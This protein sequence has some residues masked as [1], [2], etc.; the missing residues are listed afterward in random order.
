MFARKPLL[1]AG[2]PPK[3]GPDARVLMLWGKVVDAEKALRQSKGT[4]GGHW[5]PRRGN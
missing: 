2:G 4:T 3:E 1:T 5:F